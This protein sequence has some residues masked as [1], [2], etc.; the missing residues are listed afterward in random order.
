MHLRKSTENLN[1][2]LDGIEE[3]QVRKREPIPDN[4]PLDE[5]ADEVVLASAR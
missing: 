4:I 3:G 5:I 2:V 1:A